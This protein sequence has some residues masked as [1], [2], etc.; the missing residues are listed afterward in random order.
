ME[1]IFVA[2]DIHG[3]YDAF[4][5]FVDK[6]GK[7]PIFICG[8]LTPYSPSF[9]YLF[10][11]ISNDVYMVKGNCDN[12]YDFSIANLY[13]P[14]RTRIEFFFN[15]Q[16]LITHGDLI[17]SAKSS[18]IQ[19]NKNDLFISGHTHIPQLYFDDNHIIYLNPGSLSRPRGKFDRSYAIIYKN[20]IEIRTLD[21]DK[22]I[23]KLNI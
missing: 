22:I 2:S 8:D 18:P 23:F 9:S 20:K 4:S 13:I 3:D 11:S 6:V 17:K 16:M 21:K 1:K 10:S 12:A 19:L 14:P 5:R 15:R 7:S